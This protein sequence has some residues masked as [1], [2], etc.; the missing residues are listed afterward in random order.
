MV[1]IVAMAIMNGFDKEFESKLFTMNYPLSIYSKTF[2]KINTQDLENLKKEFPNLKYS[3]YISSQVITKKG[4]RLEGG[5]LFGVN[6][7]KE[8][9]MNEVLK[10]ALKNK[11]I[12]KYDIVV[13]KA[14]RDRNLLENNDKLTL[15]FTASDP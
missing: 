13:G 14:I 5:L 11:K 6:F 3:P 1:L 9:P 2:Q 15:I 8:I 12:G 7:Q 4:N 10:T